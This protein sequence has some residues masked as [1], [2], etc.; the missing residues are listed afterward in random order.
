M[1]APGARR[2]SPAAGAG[3]Q[4][5][6]TGQVHLLDGSM[7]PA[8]VKLLTGRRLVNE[9]VC[10]EL[11]RLLGFRVPAGLLVKVLRADY[12]QYF[13][14]QPDTVTFYYAF[15]TMS[16]KGQPLTQRFNLKDFAVARWFFA[17][18]KSWQPI[19]AFDCWIANR[20]RHASNIMV[21]EQLNTWLIDH[22]LALC[23]DQPFEALDFA[24][25]SV[26][27]VVQEY[28]TSITPALREEALKEAQSVE[29]LAGAVDVVGAIQDSAA[30]FH[31]TAKESSA[32]AAYLE[33]RRTQVSLLMSK[34]LGIP[35]LV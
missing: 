8:F 30:N 6:L 19:A 33:K 5:T 2:L 27:R 28:A 16:I 35:L 34:T 24:A 11:A 18:Q 31:C 1:L 23:G 29:R 10:N 13:T 20:D 26:N 3:V 12:E 22:D 25:E 21:D 7:N 14:G 32:L 15:G 9:L 17:S 4:V